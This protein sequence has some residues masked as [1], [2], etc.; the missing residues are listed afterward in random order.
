M[1]NP[2]DLLSRYRDAC[3]CGYNPLERMIRSRMDQDSK[4]RGKF[5]SSTSFPIDIYIYNQDRKRVESN[6]IGD[7]F[8]SIITLIVIKFRNVIKKRIYISSCN[9]SCNGERIIPNYPPPSLQWVSFQSWKCSNVSL[10][11][12]R[13]STD[14]RLHP[15]DLKLSTPRDIRLGEGGNSKLV[16]LASYFS[17]ERFEFRREN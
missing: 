14:D 11:T 1:Q 7:P 8:Q 2:S 10:S 15:S 13:E 17:S 6:S 16:R 9:F 3:T 12:D 5:S 4:K